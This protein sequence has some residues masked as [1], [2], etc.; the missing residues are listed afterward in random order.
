MQ[1]GSSMGG[2]C[3]GVL[4]KENAPSPPSC[5]PFKE[6]HVFL[7]PKL[8]LS[9]GEIASALM[10]ALAQVASLSLNYCSNLATPSRAFG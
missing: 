1:S 6:P 3:R 10:A 4:G 9:T 8:G 5:I 2:S 7:V